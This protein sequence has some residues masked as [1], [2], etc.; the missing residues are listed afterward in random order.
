MKTWIWD[1]Q[2][3]L[4]TPI[5]IIIIIIFKWSKT[6][7]QLTDRFIFLPRCALLD[8]WLPLVMPVKTVFVIRKDKHEDQRAI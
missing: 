8:C 7:E 3:N 2:K 4:S 5:I 6:I 1:Q